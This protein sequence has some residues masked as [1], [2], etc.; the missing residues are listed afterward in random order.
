MT[1]VKYMD[2]VTQ[3]SGELV[4]INECWRENTYGLLI[5]E[6]VAD[7][8]GGS[9]KQCHR[10]LAT[11][12]KRLH[13]KNQNSRRIHHISADQACSVHYYTENTQ[14]GRFSCL[15]RKDWHSQKAFPF[16]DRH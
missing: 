7:G 10:Y 15:K 16:S 12:D 5:E 4:I 3:I 2:M 13:Q 1:I 11:Y 14:D 6:V 9:D 8:G